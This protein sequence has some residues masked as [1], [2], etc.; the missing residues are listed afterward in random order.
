LRALF[1]FLNNVLGATAHNLKANRQV[2]LVSVATITVALSILGLFLL[3]FSNLKSMMS[4]WDRQVQLIVYLDD[5]VSEDQKS[6]LRAL[7]EGHPEVEEV[8]F[9]SREEAWENFRHSF[10]GGA[11]FIQDLDFNPLPG[12]FHMRFKSSPDRLDKIKDF[13][14]VLNKQPGVESLEYGE[15]WVARFEKFMIFIQV[16]LLAVGGLLCLGLILII[17]NTIKLS[18][19]SR[20]DEIELMRLIGATNRYIRTPFLLEGVCVG[21]FGAVASLAL[22]KA[23]HYYIQLRFQESLDFLTRGV[24]IQFLPF[25][26]SVSMV[27]VS[28]AVGLMGSYYSIHQFLESGDRQ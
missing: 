5:D 27:V 22:L 19:Y 1:Q 10:S 15:K 12:S 7:F 3:V 13:A 2:F 23:M 11:D 8:A 6:K 24:V 14:Q 16:F 4:T 17:S 25:S 21:F 9:T 20:Q 28:M 26:W 18:Y